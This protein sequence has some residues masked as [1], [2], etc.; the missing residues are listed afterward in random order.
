M[1]RISL[2]TVGCISGL[3]VL[4]SACKKEEGVGGTSTITG[5]V[6]VRQYNANFTVLMEQ[7]YAPDEDVF[8]IYGDDEAYGDKFATNYDGTYRFEYLR[9]GE[10]TVFAYS[11]DSLKYPTNHEIPVIRKV[12][13]NGKNQTVVV[14]DIIILK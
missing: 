11:E 8:I 6:L 2:I 10:Y 12:K 7:Y 9:E 1:N 5:K 14:D 3:I 13:I 4:L